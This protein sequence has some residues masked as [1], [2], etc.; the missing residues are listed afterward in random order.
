MLESYVIDRRVSPY[1]NLYEFVQLR[2]T[3]KVLYMDTEA[4]DIRAKPTP[5]YTDDPKH[6]LGI[7]YL[8]EW[9]LKVPRVPGSFQWYQFI[10]NWLEHRISIKL[11]YSFIRNNSLDFLRCVD[12][13]G[14]CSRR[15]LLWEY[16]LHRD[17]RLFKP[18][19][20]LYDERPSKRY[21]SGILSGGNLQLCY[22]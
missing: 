13:S 6:R 8:I 20:Y 21:K 12:L 9:S 18:T 1:L 16:L 7:H 17:R 15:R 22:G 5:M 14:L 2:K 11:M 19:R 3:C 4:W 10:V